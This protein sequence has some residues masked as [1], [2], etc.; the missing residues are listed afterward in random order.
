MKKVTR[1]YRNDVTFPLE[2]DIA[3]YAILHSTRVEY[4][5][6]KIRA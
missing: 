1:D 2:L 6:P 5:E 4:Q 3:I